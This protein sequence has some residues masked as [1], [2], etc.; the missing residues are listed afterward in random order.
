MA[1]AARPATA[2]SAQLPSYLKR[3]LQALKRDGMHE[4]LMSAL[5]SKSD[6]FGP[7]ALLVFVTVQGKQPKPDMVVRH[8]SLDSIRTQW[9]N[10]L[11]RVTTCLE[12]HPDRVPCFVMIDQSLTLDSR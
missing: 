12:S 8:L 6:A 2:Q 4:H 1:T 7:G 5:K 3:V 9:P 11:D 10:I